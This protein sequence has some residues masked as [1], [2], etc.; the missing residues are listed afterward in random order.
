MTDAPTHLAAVAFDLDDTLFPQR[1]WL[2][3]AWTAVAARA[4]DD[5]IN[6]ARL[7][8]A[9]VAIASEGTDRGRIID[10][11][12]ASLGA[13]DLDVAPLVDAFRSYRAPSVTPYAG[14]RDSLARLAA[15]V[16]L[17]LVSDGDPA[18]Q[19]AKLDATGLGDLFTAVVWSDEHGREHRKP[20]PL[21][22]RV[23]LTEL[24][25]APDEAVFVGDRPGKDVAGAATAG[26]HAVR[27]RTGEWSDQP[28]D[29]RAFAVVDTVAD[30]CALL[31]PL[32]AGGQSSRTATSTRNS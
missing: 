19:Q 8:D 7:R 25:C 14:T 10:R 20:D 3:G 17:A 21:P 5:G 22:F 4:A 2:D 28:D 30:A 12:L 16:P 15:H 23:A 6:Q 27:V 29:E 24:G 32:V 9:L 31:Q 13:A 11:A 1:A 26:M 18:I